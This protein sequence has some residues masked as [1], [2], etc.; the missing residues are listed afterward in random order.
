[1]SSPTASAAVK[2]VQ[3][4]AS[5]AA[6]TASAA[7]S[8]ASSAAGGALLKARQLSFERKKKD[9][10][11][12]SA[13]PPTGQSGGEMQGALKDTGAPAA[14]TPKSS[15]PLATAAVKA[16]QRGAS[17]AGGA[18]LKARQLS[19]ERK[20]KGH[21]PTAPS[22]LTPS[23]MP[24]PSATTTAPEAATQRQAPSDVSDPLV[25]HDGRCTEFWPPTSS[26][27]HFAGGS[28]SI[29]GRPVSLASPA[30][31]TSR[32]KQLAAEIDEAIL[33]MK[34]AGRVN[35][36]VMVPA[37]PPA[38]AQ[39]SSGRTTRVQ[40]VQ[41]AASSASH[42]AIKAVQRGASAAASTA[43]S[44]AGGAL[45]KARQLSFERKKKDKPPESAIPPS[46]EDATGGPG[47]EAV[48]ATP[49]G[50][51]AAPVATSSAHATSP[52]T[53]SPPKGI[54]PNSRPEKSASPSRSRIAIRQNSFERKKKDRP[55]HEEAIVALTA[56]RNDRSP[57]AT[58]QAAS[59][60]AADMLTPSNAPSMGAPPDVPIVEDDDQVNSARDIALKAAEERK[61]R[62][63]ELQRRQNELQSRKEKLRRESGVECIGVD[64]S[65]TEAPQ[66]LMHAEP[67][68][69]TDAPGPVNALAAQFDA[70][71]KEELQGRDGIFG[72]GNGLSSTD[73]S[74]AAGPLRQAALEGLMHAVAQHEEQEA[75][76]QQEQSLPTTVNRAL[77]T[78]TRVLNQA[79]ATQPQSRFARFLERFL[80]LLLVAM[81][82]LTLVSAIPE[83]RPFLEA[84]QMA[85]VRMRATGSARSV[86][87]EIRAEGDALC[88]AYST[89]L[90]TSEYNLLQDP[91][92]A[93]AASSLSSFVST[94][95]VQWQALSVEAVERAEIN[96]YLQSICGETGYR[97]NY[98]PF[99]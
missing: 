72:P 36:P 37:P 12:E 86:A 44:A 19:F 70:A 16:I 50:A 71:S 30:A 48:A 85:Y 49:F 87:L 8:T 42:G 35:P 61:G 13:T 24:M 22:S 51:S 54:T 14:S 34:S 82:A 9:K 21:S 62:L 7:A 10:P 99:S 84:S 26:T 55:L 79:A 33:Y 83:A 64:A 17:S 95:G 58:T 75:A 59:Q 53:S 76:L 80:L 3:R 89:A 73:A 90:S 29:S 5:A 6:S 52:S 93:L 74:P 60:A 69:V 40:A 47:S 43:S 56:A 98:V 41:S 18:L 65:Q 68:I 27:A 45:L 97:R 63:A 28:T 81:W 67:L 25:A 92:V 38:S 4:G 78:G 91:E 77:E 15:T 46:A 23:D 66:A 94:R 1:M 31:A 2:A 57:T 39:G 20:K 11:P 96:D 88:R 32:P